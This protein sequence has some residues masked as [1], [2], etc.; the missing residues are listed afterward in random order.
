[1]SKKEERK[2]VFEMLS[3]GKITVEDA[4]TLLDALDTSRDTKRPMG[5]AGVTGFDPL[6]LEDFQ[7]ELDDHLNH[8]LEGLDDLETLFEDFDSGEDWEK[9]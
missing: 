3:E 1:M 6:N 4:E 9:I 8:A 7:I 5:F 2:M